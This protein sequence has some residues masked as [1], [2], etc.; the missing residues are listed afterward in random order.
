MKARTKKE[1]KILEAKVGIA[2][3]LG[4]LVIELFFTY[5]LDFHWFG[6]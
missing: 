6:W 5:A 4:M 2:A 1:W 3:L